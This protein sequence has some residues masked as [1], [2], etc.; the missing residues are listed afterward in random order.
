MFF[1]FSPTKR[2]LAENMNITN[3]AD[4]DEL[5]AS[6]SVLQRDMKV[7]RLAPDNVKM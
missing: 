2:P 5:Q 1:C 3:I 7:S 4:D 6:M